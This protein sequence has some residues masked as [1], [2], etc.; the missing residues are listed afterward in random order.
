MKEL[1][2]EKYNFPNVF[3]SMFLLFI[4]LNSGLKESATHFGLG[5]ILQN[6]KETEQQHFEE[7]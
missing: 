3:F 6:L 7:I 4:S 2:Q 5:A 1:F